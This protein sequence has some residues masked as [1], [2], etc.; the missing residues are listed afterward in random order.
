MRLLALPHQC[1]MFSAALA[2]QHIASSPSRAKMRVASTAP[3]GTHSS[4]SNAD[5]AGH[6]PFPKLAPAVVPMLRFAQPEPSG[7][8]TL[9]NATSCITSSASLFFSDIWAQ[10]AR[11]P[12]IS[13]RRLA[14]GSMRPSFKKTGTVLHMSRMSLS[15]TPTASTSPSCSTRTGSSLMLQSSPFPRLL[16]AKTRGAWLMLFVDCCVALT[17][18]A[19]PRSR[20][21]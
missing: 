1:V 21:A 13:L 11:I 8:S 17:F 14:G 19:P 9:L 12:H 20:P 4:I 2:G 5:R 6:E 15:R 3:A 10:H 7:Q 16:A 18:Q